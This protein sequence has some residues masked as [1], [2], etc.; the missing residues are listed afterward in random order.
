[1]RGWVHIV[2]VGASTI[3]N[4]IRERVLGVELRDVEEALRDGRLNPE[5]TRAKLVEF[6]SRDYRSASAELNTCMGLILEGFTR[7]VQQWVY[8]LASDTEVGRVC[9]ASLAEFLTEFS[10]ENL[11]G[12]LSVIDPIIVEHLGSQERFND[13]LAN[14]FSKIVEIIAGHKGKGDMVFLHATGG[15]KPEIAIAVLAANSPMG[16]VPTFYL[17]EHFREV[18]RIPALP[19]TFRRSAKFENLMKRI[20]MAESV[21][22]RRYEQTYG[23]QAVRR[24]IELGWIREEDGM[25]KATEIG[26]LL[27][28]ILTKSSRKR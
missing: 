11:N 15:F 17:H 4:A 9:S 14:L 19:L 26:R 22:K 3:A 13:G 16:G 23:K 7:G 24:A 6:I 12:M 21:N 20:I 28:K 8:L 2:L 18:I 25:L 5:E 27:W 10:R 1:M